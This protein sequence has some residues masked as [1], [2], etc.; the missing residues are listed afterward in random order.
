M[1]TG[2]SAAYMTVLWLL[3]L[4]GIDRSPEITQD[5]KTVIVGVNHFAWVDKNFS[6]P[7]YFPWQLFDAEP[8]P[9]ELPTL[10]RISVGASDDYELVARIVSYYRDHEAAFQQMWREKDPRRARALYAMNLVHVSHPY[11]PDEVRET[12]M[13][14]VTRASASSCR[15][16]AIYQSRILDAFGLP[17]RYVAISS[18]FHGWIEVK[19]R[20]QW[21]IFD[22][23]ANL[24]I[25]RSSFELLEGQARRY[26]TFYTPWTDAG[27]PDARRFVE[28]YQP[29]YF[30]PGALRMNMPGLGV[31]FMT[32]P[33]LHEKG[34]RLE[35]WPNFCPGAF[36]GL[37]C[38]K[39]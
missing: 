6:A 18:G 31:Y 28:R 14:Y 13:D 36:R 7:A 17:W 9:D 32:M 33:Y 4:Y 10:Q 26:R 39:A 2:L 19:V 34:L 37:K 30:Q 35:I 24:W 15:S 38:L 11:G 1:R 8:P 23:T 22:A 16:F 29:H 27:R 20:E 12:F 21:E 5:T 3:L 25:D